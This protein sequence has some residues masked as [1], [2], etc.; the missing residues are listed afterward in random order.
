MLRKP[1]RASGWPQW[2]CVIFAADGDVDHQH[3]F[4]LM[5]LYRNLGAGMIKHISAVKHPIEMPETRAWAVC[6]T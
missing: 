1:W 6:R 4:I 5:S 2:K 3:P